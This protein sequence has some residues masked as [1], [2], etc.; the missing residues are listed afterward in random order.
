MRAE[1]PLSGL[2][3]WNIRTAVMSV[4]AGRLPDMGRQMFPGAY[5][6]AGADG[7]QGLPAEIVNRES[8]GMWRGVSHPARGTSG[9]GI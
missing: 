1:D 8:A 5:T 6:G 7:G 9:M 2:T 4:W 3:V